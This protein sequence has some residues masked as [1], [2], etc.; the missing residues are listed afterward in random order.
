V[1]TVLVTSPWV[2]APIIVP[3]AGALLAWLPGWRRWSMF[4]WLTGLAML[5]AVGGL[6][7]QVGTHGPLRYAVGGWG[8]PLGID[9][10]VDGLAALMLLMTAVVGAG[11]S[12]YA[13]AYFTPMSARAFWPLWLF[14]WAALNALFLSADIFNLYVTLEL[15]TLASVA[16]IALAGGPALS[17]GL[18]YLLAALLGSLAYLL[19]V[20]LVYGSYGVLDIESLG[21]TMTPGPVTAVAIGLMATGLMLK[22]ALFPLH[23]W[24]PS[25]HASAP[26]PVSAALSALVVKASIYI[27]LRLWLQAFPGAL[28]GSAHTLLGA[29]GAGAIL[30]GSYRALRAQRLKLLVAY[31]TVAQ[32]GYL[33][34][35]FPLLAAPGGDAL[36]AWQGGIYHALSHASA[37]AAMFLAA[38][39]LLH[40]LGHDRIAEIAGA[41]QRFPL[42]LFAFGLAG[43]S[44]MGLPPSGGFVAK[45][46]LL[47]AALAGGQWGWAAVIVG[48][49][50]LAAAYVFRVL[51]PAF[52]R[53]VDPPAH[54]QPVP[55]ALELSALVLAVLSLLLGFIAPLPLALADVGWPLSGGRP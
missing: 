49:G 32:I 2:V 7:A 38:G 19:G 20:A 47:S 5:L 37:K 46:L 8:A 10:Y 54:W 26:A 15:V 40:A 11:I 4:A 6:A 44:L 33:F 25:A 21:R 52:A 14:L 13:A 24:L 29:L 42:T 12:V 9:L 36:T 28:A 39:T 45:W 22:S 34:L 31:S 17:A 51:R 30:W 53:Q 16:L 55:R 48:G 35:L 23:Y 1:V 18:R 41:A 50:L 27:L 3:L 43:V